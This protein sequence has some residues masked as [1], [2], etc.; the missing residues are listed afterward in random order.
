MTLKETKG[1][2]F[3]IFFALATAF[4]Y[5]H[6][7]PFGIA[8]FGQWQTSNGVVNAISKTDLVN[9]SIEIN[10]P[11]IIRR[12]IQE[13]K[14]IVLDVRPLEFYEEGHL[15]GA[16]PFP[17]MEFDTVIDK[18][19]EMTD[20]QS[21]ILIYCSGF[22]CMDSHNVATNLENMRFTNVKVYPGG[23]RQWQEMGHDIEKN[24]K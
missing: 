10:N 13:K 3:L 15:P 24:E 20:Q 9:A 4:F 14:R 21:P 2:F 22:E 6:F 12:I 18:L 19:L 16:L 23:F 1:T 5:N 11:E 17:L 7:S 8:L